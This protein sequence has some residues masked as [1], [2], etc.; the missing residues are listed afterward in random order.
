MSHD[1]FKISNTQLIFT[2]FNFNF[3]LNFYSY[4]TESIY[5]NQVLFYRDGEYRVDTLRFLDMLSGLDTSS[6]YTQF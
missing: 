2:T 5:I 1:I 4:K 3:T 6:G